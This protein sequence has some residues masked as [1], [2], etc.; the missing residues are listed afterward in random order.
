MAQPFSLTII[1]AATPSLGIGLRGALPW[2]LPTE[3]RYFA[4]VTSRVGHSTPP[5]K[6]AVIMGRKTWDSIP[7]KF[8]PLKDRVNV[9]LSRSQTWLDE[10][11][12]SA[13]AAGNG[14][15]LGAKSLNEAVKLLQTRHA[16]VAGGD[17]G[18][19]FVIGGGE[20]YKAALELDETKEL[21]LTRIQGQWECDTFLSVDPDAD[22]GWERA[23]REEWKA[24]TGEFDT[25][26]K[27][28]DKD[29]EFEYRLYTKKA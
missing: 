23:N 11:T 20:V 8:R 28:K 29:V 24:W 7:P 14:E 25:E 19:V 15:V 17:I 3:M 27:Q 26:E 10:V 9:V 21:L 12:A 18:K 6:N 16:T 13:A 4:R 2:R 22:G 1:V 5:V